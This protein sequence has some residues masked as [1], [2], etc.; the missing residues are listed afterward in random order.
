MNPLKTDK[1]REFQTY[2]KFLKHKNSIQIS[3]KSHI[4]DNSVQYKLR[5]RKNLL[6]NSFSMNNKY[7]KISIHEPGIA[8]KIKKALRI[9]E[10]QES[11]I[12]GNK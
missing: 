11:Y 6:K 12:L 7:S 9:I 10:R 5:S 2:S 8:E 4:L 3:Q 1:N